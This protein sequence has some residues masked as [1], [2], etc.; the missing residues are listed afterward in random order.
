MSVSITGLHDWEW[1]PA[2]A[3]ADDDDD[4]NDD[5]D[6]S[7]PNNIIRL[8]QLLDHIADGVRQDDGHYV[9]KI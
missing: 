4:D 2:A 1:L 6:V 7:L 3:A 9:N 5:D 8:F